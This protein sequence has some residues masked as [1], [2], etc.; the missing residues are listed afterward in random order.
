MNRTA[1]I[2]D[3]FQSSYQLYYVLIKPDGFYAA[4]NPYFFRKF[5]LNENSISTVHSFETIHP[6][7]HAA[8]AT[9]VEQC[10][11]QPGKSFSVV[12]RKPIPLSGFTY[13]KWEFTYINSDEEGFYIQCVGFDISEEIEQKEEL[14]YANTVIDTKQEMLVQMLSNSV[15]V[16]ILVNRQNE[17]LY[18]SPNMEQVLGYTDEDLLGKSGFSVLHPDDM[19]AATAVFQAELVNPGQNKAV[20]LRYG[21]K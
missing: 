7:D 19:E 20:D 11:Q 14:A 1:L 15:D 3:I 21:L 16:F 5:Q 17:V 18:C 2:P 4:A 13:T 12:L 10:I 9:V 8:C 6:G